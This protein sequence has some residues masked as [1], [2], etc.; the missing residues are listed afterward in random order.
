[1]LQ[2]KNAAN[3]PLQPPPVCR[4]QSGSKNK[5]TR[6]V[7]D[8]CEKTAPVNETMQSTS[9]RRKNS[10]RERIAPVNETMQSTSLR[11]K[12]PS[13]VNDT[14]SFRHT[15]P[16][17]V[18]ESTSLRRKNPS[19]I[20]ENSSLRRKN[21]VNECTLLTHKLREDRLKKKQDSQSRYSSN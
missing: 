2:R 12:N 6:G 4:K 20:N 5:Q 7:I 18:N 3:K 17:P 13:P 9:L 1:M 8:S 16:S 21:P 11:H 14:A 10:S 19:P 15:N